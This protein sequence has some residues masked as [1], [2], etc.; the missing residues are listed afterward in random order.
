MSTQQ[1]FTKIE[2]ALLPG[3]RNQ[4]GRAETPEE[5]KTIFTS[6]VLDFFQNAFAGELEVRF[7]DVT[8]QPDAEPFYKLDRRL[9]GSLGFAPVWQGSDL[10][11][12]IGRMADTAAKRY[13]FLAKPVDK[14][15]SGVRMESGPHSR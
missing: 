10:P 13:H 2:H 12:I 14:T 9:K 5:V 15:K 6:S 1:S 11:Q 8:L 3:F 4:I 7:E